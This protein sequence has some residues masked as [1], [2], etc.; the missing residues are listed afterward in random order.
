M[1]DDVHALVDDVSQL[2]LEPRGM[3][4]VPDDAQTA[5]IDTVSHMCRAVVESVVV[6]GPRRV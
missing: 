6:C 2:H 4:L 1:A 5:P 3:I